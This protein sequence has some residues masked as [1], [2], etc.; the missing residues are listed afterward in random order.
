MVAV[1]LLIVGRA[2]AGDLNPTDAPGP[3]MHTLEEIYQNQ[4]A[5]GELQKL[6]NMTEVLDEIL[7]KVSW[8]STDVVSV[9]VATNVLQTFDAGVPKTGQTPAYR[10]GDD[11]DLE[12]GVTWPN[13][14]FTVDGTGNN[15]VDNLTG[16]IWTR[17][18]DIWGKL[19]WTGA[20]ANCNSLWWGGYDDWRLPNRKEL[21]S[22]VHLGVSMPCIPNTA[23][24]GKWTSGDPFTNVQSDEYWSSTAN[25]VDTV[26]AWVVD[27]FDGGITF[28]PMAGETMQCSAWPVRGG[29]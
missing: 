29:Q 13:P 17:N 5:L 10:T 26:S 2:T 14:R 8:I 20:V 24:T 25:A 12:K 7:Q 22:L 27:L 4:E 6:Q 16:L 28:Y 15:V 19:S 1:G 23:G 9:V 11:G 3:T 21:L 18:A